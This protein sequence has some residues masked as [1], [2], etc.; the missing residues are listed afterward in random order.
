MCLPQSL[1]TL[2]PNRCAA[3]CMTV[4]GC[5]FLPSCVCLL[6]P[7]VCQFRRAAYASWFREHLPIGQCP[8]CR[9]SRNTLQFYFKSISSCIL[10][11]HRGDIKPSLSFLC[12]DSALP[13]LFWL[14]LQISMKACVSTM[15]P[16]LLIQLHAPCHTS[17]CPP[18]QGRPLPAPA[19]PGLLH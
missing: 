4:R 9:T 1:G 6:S 8:I 12:A 11:R 19:L 15:D 10:V 7:F 17:A 18:L 16:P 3:Q 13:N 14:L 5:S 2:N